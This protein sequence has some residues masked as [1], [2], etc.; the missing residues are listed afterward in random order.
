MNINLFETSQD[1]REGYNAGL[2]VGRNQVLKEYNDTLIRINDR[3]IKLLTT[4]TMK[5]VNTYE[6]T[7]TGPGRPENTDHSL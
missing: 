3:I 4:M 7:T 1:F 2:L 5:E 6:Q